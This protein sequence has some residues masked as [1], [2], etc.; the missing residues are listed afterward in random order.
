MAVAIALTMM[1]AGT[2][3]VALECA[4]AGSVLLGDAVLMARFA[5]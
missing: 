2:I 4:I 1:V 5:T 3:S